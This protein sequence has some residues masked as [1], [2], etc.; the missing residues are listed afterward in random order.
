MFEELPRLARDVF[1]ACQEA[2]L[3]DGGSKASHAP[4]ALRVLEAMVWVVPH[5]RA[6]AERY[7]SAAADAGLA[8]AA[9]L[10]LPDERRTPTQDEDTEQ[11]APPQGFQIYAILASRSVG[12]ALEAAL[13]E[14]RQGTGDHWD[15]LAN[16]LLR[17]ASLS[18]GNRQ[19]L[20]DHPPR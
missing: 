17:C 3:R 8:P 6:Y 9:A 18:P 16:S 20:R 7:E 19:V 1:A 13:R 14:K 15:L 4:G 5:F 2:P 10:C 11:E 12:S